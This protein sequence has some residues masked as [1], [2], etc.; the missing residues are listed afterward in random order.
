M[1]TNAL[2]IIVP[3][4]TAVL[5]AG[6]SVWYQRWLTN[7]TLGQQAELTQKTL[8]HER[9]IARDQRVHERVADT[10][11]Q[12][13]E[14]FDW[15]ME[16]V[17]ATQPI[18]EPGPVAPPEPDSEALRPVQARIAAWASPEVKAMIYGQWIPV[19]NEFFAAAVYLAT[20]RQAQ[21]QGREVEADYG[22]SVGRQYLKV[23]ALR[24]QLHGIVRDIEN[25]A[26]EELRG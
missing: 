20:M 3:G 22:I 19:R 8:D 2:A 14:M 7:K 21:D 5:L 9:T 26:N 6:I 13:L 15:I 23:D 11:V 25:R 17:I 10:Y 4:A 24:K 16:I 12:M 18:L 1:D